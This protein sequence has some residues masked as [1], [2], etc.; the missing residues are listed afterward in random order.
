M[1]TAL[2]FLL[3]LTSFGLIVAVPVSLATPGDWE[4]SKDTYNQ[5]IKAWVLLVIGIALIDGVSSSF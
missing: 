2:V 4:E 1:I 3:V 5:V